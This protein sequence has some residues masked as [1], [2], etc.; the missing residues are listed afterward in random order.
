MLQPDAQILYCSAKHITLTAPAPKLDTGQHRVIGLM[1]QPLNE[2][3]E[4][5]TNKIDL[6]AST[7]VQQLQ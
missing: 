5:D 2:R 6:L 1:E 4:I 3:T 7:I